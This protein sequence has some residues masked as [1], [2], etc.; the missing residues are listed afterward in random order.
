MEGL[1][2]ESLLSTHIRLSNDPF[3]DFHITQTDNYVTHDEEEIYELMRNM[4]KQ[5]NYKLSKAQ[6]I[7]LQEIEHQRSAWET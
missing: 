3:R 4:E 5:E 2:S 1:G 6:Q 7:L